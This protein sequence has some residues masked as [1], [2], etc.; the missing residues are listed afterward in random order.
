MGYSQ[1]LWPSTVQ[2]KLTKLTDMVKKLLVIV[3]LCN[4]A[5][6]QL[7]ILRFS[8]I[9][10]DKFYESMLLPNRPRPLS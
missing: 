9:S 6:R 4:S 1:F 2:V 5:Q 7:Y 8:A 3:S 10:S